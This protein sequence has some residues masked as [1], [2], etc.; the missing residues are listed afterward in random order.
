MGRKTPPFRYYP[1]WTEA[2][3]WSFIRS[4]L[5][6]AWNKSPIKRDWEKKHRRKYTGSDKR[7]KW[8]YQCN[9]C[10]KWFKRKDVQVDHKIPAGTLRSLDD[11]KGFV[12][13]LFFVEE[14]DLQWLCKQ[15]HTQK[16]K[17]DKR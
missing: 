2:R 7:T 1:Q 3:F 12:K 6:Q 5:R 14:N 10:K 13:R 8:E 11:L 17:K 15:C 4:A 9:N 16:T